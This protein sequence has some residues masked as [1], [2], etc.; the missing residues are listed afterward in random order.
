MKKPSTIVSLLPFA[1]LV[2]LMVLVIRTF[3]ADALEGA[4][5]WR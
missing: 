4:V 5:R 1:I 3:G 2:A